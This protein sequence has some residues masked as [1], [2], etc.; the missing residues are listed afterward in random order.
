MRIEFFYDVVS[1]YSLLAFEVVERYAPIWGA[2][3]V[4]RPFFLG[5]VMQA[6]GNA[7]PAA[8]PARAKYLAKDMQVQLN[9]CGVTAAHVF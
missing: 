4:H 2:T 7:P 6:T 1:P 9:T 5:G 8:L 3:V